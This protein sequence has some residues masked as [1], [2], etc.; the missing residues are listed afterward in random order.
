MKSLLTLTKASLAIRRRRRSRS[1]SLD[2]SSS[3]AS[4]S[5]VGALFQPNLYQTP[6]GASDMYFPQSGGTL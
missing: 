3:W 5:V 2:L 4:E 6:R 1:R